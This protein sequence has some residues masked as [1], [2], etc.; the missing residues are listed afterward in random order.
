MKTALF[1]FFLSHKKSDPMVSAGICMWRHIQYNLGATI[2]LYFLLN[3]TIDNCHISFCLQH[4]VFLISYMQLLT[5][6]FPPSLLCSSWNKKDIR[7]KPKSTI[8]DPLPMDA[9]LL[10]TVWLLTLWVLS[11]KAITCLLRKKH[12]MNHKIIQ[13]FLKTLHITHLFLSKVC[14]FHI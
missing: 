13:L 2:F 8:N 5:F 12:L 4:S 10:L 11:G 7:N 3:K 1:F 14:I 6:F 9:L